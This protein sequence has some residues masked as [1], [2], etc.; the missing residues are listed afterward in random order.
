MARIV[1]FTR[2][3]KY[4]LDRIAAD[5]LEMMDDFSITEEQVLALSEDYAREDL[6]CGWGHTFDGD[7]DMEVTDE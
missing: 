5:Y 2:T 6:S 7:L 3:V 4:D 1:T